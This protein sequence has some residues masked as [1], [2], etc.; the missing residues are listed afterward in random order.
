MTIIIQYHVLNRAPIRH[1]V[2]F[3]DHVFYDFY[4]F[5]DYSMHRWIRW[6]CAYNVAWKDDRCFLRRPRNL[7][8]RSSSRKSAQILNKNTTFAR[9]NRNSLHWKLFVS[10]AAVESFFT[11]EFSVPDS[12]W[13]CNSSRDRNIWFVV[14]CRPL[15]SSRPSGDAMQPTRIPCLLPPGRHTWKP[16]A[17]RKC[18]ESYSIKKFLYRFSWIERWI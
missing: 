9:W 18:K 13:K 12:R 2:V 10:N 8:L 11:R 4:L 1:V 14:E 16:T 3:I 5:L 7:I 17:V 6:H 15:H